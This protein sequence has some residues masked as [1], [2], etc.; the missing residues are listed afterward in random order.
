MG[1]AVRLRQAQGGG[2]FEPPADG[3]L[4]PDDRARAILMEADRALSEIAGERHWKAVRQAV[5]EGFDLLTDLAPITGEIKAIV[6]AHDFLRQ[7]EAA[8]QAGPAGCC[9]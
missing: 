4:L 6:E 1:A 3:A 9:R 8:E 5:R 2:D 7:A